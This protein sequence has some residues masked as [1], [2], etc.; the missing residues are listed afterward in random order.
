MLKKCSELNIQELGEN[1]SE[2]FTSNIEFTFSDSGLV[3][4]LK[5]HTAD[6]GEGG[7]STNESGLWFKILELEEFSNVLVNLSP[8]AF[9]KKNVNKAYNFLTQR[10][11]RIVQLL[12]KC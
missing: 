6:G 1:S 8:V 3:V 7:N 4:I 10:R 11:E 12:F 2:D 9:T 5:F